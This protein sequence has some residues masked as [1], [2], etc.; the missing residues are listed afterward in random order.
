MT[1]TTRSKHALPSRASTRMR[2]PWLLASAGAALL[3]LTLTLRQE[4]VA[5]Q[6]VDLGL[7]LALML[8]ALLLLLAGLRPARAL[9]DAV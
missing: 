1:S 2:T 9:R 8:A 6:T 5:R 3:A 7:A 4:A